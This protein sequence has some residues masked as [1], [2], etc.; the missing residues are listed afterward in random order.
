[1]QIED[2]IPSYNVDLSHYH[3]ITC[4]A[5]KAVSRPF[6]T[7]VPILVPILEKIPFSLHLPFLKIADCNVP[8]LVSIIRI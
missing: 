3:I 8:F 6:L 1:M 7:Q 5:P 2:V 4:F